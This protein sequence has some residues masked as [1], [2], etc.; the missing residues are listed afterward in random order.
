MKA[1][2]NCIVC[3]HFALYDY[4]DTLSGW[5]RY[6]IAIVLKYMKFCSYH[7]VMNEAPN[8]NSVKRV[9]NIVLNKAPNSNNATC[10]GNNVRLTAV[11]GARLYLI[12][13]MLPISTSSIIPD[14]TTHQRYHFY[15]KLLSQSHSGMEL[16]YSVPPPLK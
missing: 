3:L 9:A 10:V 12:I 16:Q 11:M 15:D 4:N 5:W 1:V 6:H 14:C 8:N 7:F 13:T 2:Y